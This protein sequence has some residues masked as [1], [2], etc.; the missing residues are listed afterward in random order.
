[1]VT[2]DCISKSSSWIQVAKTWSPERSLN[3]IPGDIF[4]LWLYFMA[5]LHG[6]GLN[7]CTLSYKEWKLTSLEPLESFRLNYM[8]KGRSN[9]CHDSSVS[10][11]CV[12][13]FFSF[14]L[15]QPIVPLLTSPLLWQSCKYK[16][17]LNS[18]D[19]R[20]CRSWDPDIFLASPAIKSSLLC[21]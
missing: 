15:W 20:F 9:L 4:H 8:Y 14:F 5:F 12:K 3:R 17:G 21:L 10:W 11:V 18:Q 19:K 1:M 7:H 16:P 2:F 6:T 13:L